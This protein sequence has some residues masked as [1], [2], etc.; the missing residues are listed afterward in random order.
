[1][2][3]VSW[4]LNPYFQCKTLKTVR[5]AS[6]LEFSSAPQGFKLFFLAATARAKL[7]NNDLKGGN[8]RQ[9]EKHD[10]KKMV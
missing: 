8:F 1:M 7:E 6:A 10:K 5:S 3:I 4:A 9:E 2:R